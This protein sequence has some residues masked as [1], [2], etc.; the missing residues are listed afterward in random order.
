MCRTR[1][2][3]GLPVG[4]FQC[5][6]E[7]FSPQVSCSIWVL[8]IG[9]SVTLFCGNSTIEGTDGAMGFRHFKGLSLLHSGLQG[10]LSCLSCTP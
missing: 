6:S 4:I 2:L 10:F 9:N 1:A 5:F 8:I 3:W 7:E